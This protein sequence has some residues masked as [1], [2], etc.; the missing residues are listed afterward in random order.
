MK[1]F[2][3]RYV[4]SLAYAAPVGAA[5]R[6]GAVVMGLACLLAVWATCHLWSEALTKPW[7][8]AGV[9]GMLFG[10]L[11]L[12]LILPFAVLHLAAA[13]YPRYLAKWRRDPLSLP[14]AF[15]FGQAQAFR[16][17]YVLIGWSTVAGALVF[18]VMHSVG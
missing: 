6:L 15:V 13:I 4:V 3:E 12:A 9:F 7:S 17:A 1:R 2:L 16:F 10:I 8:I 14:E 5:E 18:A 11:L